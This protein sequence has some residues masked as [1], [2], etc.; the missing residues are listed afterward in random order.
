MAEFPVDSHFGELNKPLPDWRKMDT[1]PD[2]NKPD[3]QW[4]DGF[5][6]WHQ[7]QGTHY[8]DKDFEDMDKG[9]ESR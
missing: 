4:E 9:H 5:D 3:D 8:T 1:D 7:A 6:E 2:E